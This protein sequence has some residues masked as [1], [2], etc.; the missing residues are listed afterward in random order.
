M[1]P[2]KHN[3]FDGRFLAKN[4][5][6]GIRRDSEALLE[7]FFRNEWSVQILRFRGMSIAP[8]PVALKSVLDTRS[9]LFTETLKAIVLRL[10][11]QIGDANPSFFFQSQISP[12]KVK[13]QIETL[14]RVIR[15]HDVFPLTNP[16]WFTKKAVLNFKAGM[17]SLAEKDTFL[18]NSIYTRE[19]LVDVCGKKIDLG[20]IEVVPCK[21]PNFA[22]A[23]PCSHCMIC[24]GGVLIPQEYLLAVGTVEPRK[25]YNRL[26]EA[27]K[28]SRTQKQGIK[29]LIIGRIGW[30]SSETVRDI[31]S[32]T[33]AILLTNICDF[34][35]NYMYQNAFAFISASVDE[36]FDIPMSE[37]I[38]HGL[39]ILASDIPVHHENLKNQ[40]NIVW[41]KP[42]EVDSITEAI[43]TLEGAKKS[44][45][46]RI[47]EIDFSG[48]FSSAINRISERISQQK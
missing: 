24:S 19:K 25:N 13:N 44:T 46:I 48:K 33:D 37:A 40:S 16:Q 47:D 21:L 42:L 9:T 4:E 7:E 41:F 3:I 23:K 28:N 32:Q 12:I 14:P 15:V 43:N 26:V 1:K 11:V 36:G 34:Q 38:S 45:S 6:S 29:L 39:S 2:E 22:S 20:S 5:P 35:L 31:R 27:W 18:V 8:E 30:L 17:Y 10:N